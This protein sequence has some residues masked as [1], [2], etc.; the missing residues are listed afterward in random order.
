MITPSQHG[1][2]FCPEMVSPAVSSSASTLSRFWRCSITNLPTPC[3]PS[4]SSSPYRLLGPFTLTSLMNIS[5]I[6]IMWAFRILR[7]TDKYWYWIVSFLYWSGRPIHVLRSLEGHIV[8][9]ILMQH[10]LIIPRMNVNQWGKGQPSED[11]G[12]LFD[13][14]QYPSVCQCLPIFSISNGSG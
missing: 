6:N 10:F 5:M 9:A 1:S 2:D 8:P 14:R 4:A 12:K 3:N 13:V 11:F 7:N